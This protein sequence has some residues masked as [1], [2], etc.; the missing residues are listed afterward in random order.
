MLVSSVPMH[1]S[2]TEESNI[3]TQLQ[4]S[5]SYS[6]LRL[7]YST[8]HMKGRGIALASY[9]MAVSFKF[10]KTWL[11]LFSFL[12]FGCPQTRD[13]ISQNLCANNAT[14]P[15]DNLS[16][17]SAPVGGQDC[18]RVAQLCDGVNDCGDGSDEGSGAEDLIECECVS[19]PQR[20]YFC[21]GGGGRGS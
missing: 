14:Q 20:K 19:R 13:Q 17:P 5:S 3:F 7:L 9:K 21:W 10:F 8:T 2:L 16:C 6:C 18:L 4:K 15:D 12:H 1:A 11:W